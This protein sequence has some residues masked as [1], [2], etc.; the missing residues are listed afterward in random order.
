MAEKIGAQ[1]LVLLGL[2]ALTTPKALASLWA[3]GFQEFL[4]PYLWLTFLSHLA[5]TVAFIVAAGQGRP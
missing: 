3:P 1:A 2:T 4:P 5:I